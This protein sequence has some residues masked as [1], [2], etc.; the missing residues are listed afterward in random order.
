MS[1]PNISGLEKK[2]VTFRIVDE[3]KVGDAVALLSRD[4]VTLPGAN[5]KFIGVCTCVR[6]GYA[7]VQIQGPATVTYSGTKPSIGHCV[8]ATDD[9]GG[10]MIDKTNGLTYLVTDIDTAAS[11]C[12]ILL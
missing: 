7:S 2:E 4:E 11:T 8:L 12:E 6:D 9:N 5:Y 3:V 1:N 10:V